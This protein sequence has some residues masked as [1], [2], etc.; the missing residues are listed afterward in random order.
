MATL[1]MT[2]ILQ[3]SSTGNKESCIL[4]TFLLSAILSDPIWT[5]LR[6]KK[7]KYRKAQNLDVIHENKNCETEINKQFPMELSMCTY[8]FSCSN[9]ELAILGNTQHIPCP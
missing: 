7:G 5:D 3:N 2:S 8:S 6:D 4:H 1:L 9:N